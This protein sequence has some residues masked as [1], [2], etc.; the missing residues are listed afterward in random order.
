MNGAVLQKIRIY[1][2]RISVAIITS[3]FVLASC[4][5]PGLPEGFVYIK[6]VVPSVELELRYTTNNNFMGRP[7]SGYNAPRGIIT[8][9]ASKALKKVQTTLA[10]QG[11]GLKIFDAYRPQQAVDAF[12]K[13]AKDLSDTTMK[14]RYYPGVHKSRLFREGYIAAK[15]G[16]SRG[17]TADLTIIRLATGQELD[18]GTHF[19]YFSPASGRAT[20]QVSEKQRA[21]RQL[22]KN[23]MEKYGFEVISTEWWHFILA[24]EPFPDTYFNFPVE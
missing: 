20:D 10:K 9:E 5:S 8:K 7:V 18:M 19:D 6:D 15:S 4:S 23:V 3:F 14:Q 16:H 11:L 12:V 17:S 22:L 13:W 2:M 1:F 21:N 24:N